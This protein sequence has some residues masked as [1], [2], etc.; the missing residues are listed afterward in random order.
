MPC[1]GDGTRTGAGTGGAAVNVAAY[2]A[3]RTV[4]AVVGYGFLTV[5][6]GLVGYQVYRWFRDGEWTHLGIVDGLHAL[7]ARCCVADGD[8]GRLSALLHWL[9]TPADWLGLH[10]VLEVMPASLA[11][12]ALSVAGNSVFIYCRD[13]IAEHDARLSEPETE[14]GTTAV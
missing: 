11:L 3:A 6:L 1:T 5:F 14:R 9:D 12:F 2:K 7:L 8:T 10:K 4:G 13:R